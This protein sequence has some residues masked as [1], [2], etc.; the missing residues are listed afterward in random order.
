MGAEN[1]IEGTLRDVGGKVQDVA[2][3]LTGDSATQAR[4]KINQAA[5]S[6][7]DTFGSALDAARDWGGSLATL[8]KDKPLVA[9]LIA[10]SAG[11]MLRA[12]THSGRGR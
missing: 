11:F 7:Q 8:T 4:G 5:G 6:A 3:G 10:A 9:L 1:R 12:L 2:G